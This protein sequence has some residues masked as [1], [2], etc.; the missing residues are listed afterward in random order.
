MATIRKRVRKKA[1]VSWQAIVRRGDHPPQRKTFKRKTDAEA[2]ATEIE[3][4]INKDDF[5]PDHPSK[6]KTVEDLLE[7]YRKTEVPGKRNQRNVNRHV[8]FW[9][10][11]IGAFKIAQVTRSQIIEIRDEMA[12]DRAP[13]TVNRYLATLRHAWGIAEVDWE[14]ATFNPLKKIKLPEPRGRNRFLSHDEIKALLKT[15]GESAH[16]LLHPLVLVALTTGARRGEI[17]GLRWG[18]VDLS[19]R[20]VLLRETKNTDERV[21]ALV[22]QVVDELRKLQKVW[23]IDDDRVFA[24]PNGHKKRTY[25][26]IE[27]AWKK[28]RAEVG[29]KDFRFHDLRHTHASHMAMNGKTLREIAE[30]LGHRTLAMV[31]RYSHL[32]DA[33]VH[34]VMEETALRILGDE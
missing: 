14:W 26:N 27:A 11:E 4:A 21:L 22:P 2:W 33:H 10:D 24:N 1:G 12:S 34:S 31:R 28:A 16:P 29:I 25:S 9:I 19:N 13:G 18:D 20:R 17:M 30:A 8:D 15:T 32:T 3:S 5:V 6:S 7:R 23:R